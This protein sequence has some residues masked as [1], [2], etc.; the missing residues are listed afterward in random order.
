MEVEREIG[1]LIPSSSDVH[2][3]AS[4]GKILNPKLLPM[5]VPL[6]CV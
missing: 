4:L 5:A 6:V 2:V 3:E 1:G